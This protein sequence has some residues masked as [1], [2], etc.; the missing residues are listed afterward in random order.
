MGM[1]TEDLVNKGMI[2]EDLVT[3]GMVTEVWL[4]RIW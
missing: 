2:T 1:V 3:V 4:V